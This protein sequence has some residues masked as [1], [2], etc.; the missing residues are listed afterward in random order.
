MD[1]IIGSVLKG[2]VFSGINQVGIMR[3]IE[4]ESMISKVVAEGAA[5][6][7]AEEIVGMFYPSGGTQNLRAMN[8]VGVADSVLYNGVSA[9]ALLSLPV[10]TD[11]VKSVSNVLPGQAAEIGAYSIF[12]ATTSAIRNYVRMW[13]STSMPNLRY[14]TDPI[15]YS[16]YIMG[17]G[18]AAKT[19]NPPA[20]G[21]AGGSAARY[22]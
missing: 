5:F 13:A 22:V 6:T 2:V 11:A 10:Y 14:L 21:G 16:Y 7:A 15:A 4:G 9:Y 12:L 1:V 8:Y 20:A 3:A 18:S 17:G 19:T